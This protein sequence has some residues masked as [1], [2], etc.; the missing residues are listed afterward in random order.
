[1]VELP[2]IKS[3]FD[4]DGL[5]KNK[6]GWFCIPGHTNYIF[7]KDL[8]KWDEIVRHNDL[9]Q[10][11]ERRHEDVS[12]SIFCR[13]M[14]KSPRGDCELPNFEIYCSTSLVN[15][16][17]IVKQCK[18]LDEDGNGF[19]NKIHMSRIIHDAIHDANA[20]LDK[21]WSVVCVAFERVENLEFRRVIKNEPA[22]IV[23]GGD[24][25]ILDVQTLTDQGRAFVARIMDET[26]AKPISRALKDYA[27]E[28]EW[29]NDVV[30][31]LELNPNTWSNVRGWEAFLV[32][33][34]SS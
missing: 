31:S 32:V 12:Q 16:L 5:Q 2:S 8:V 17:I 19:A 20:N 29:K 34:L 1:M 33:N 4:T 13:Y 26:L 11:L 21:P 7:Q 25:S 30:E 24:C 23:P 18:N 22:V 15:A 14:I 9:R 3:V 28:H 6:E 27:H 10:R